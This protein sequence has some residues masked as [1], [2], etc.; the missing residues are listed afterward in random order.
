MMKNTIRFLAFV[1]L[2]SFH[3]FILGARDKV[4]RELHEEWKPYLVKNFQILVSGFVS[5]KNGKQ[6]HSHASNG[7]LVKNKNQWNN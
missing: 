5:N 7:G 2:S 3:S 1:L 4:T 6:N